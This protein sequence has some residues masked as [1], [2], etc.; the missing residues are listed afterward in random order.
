[1]LHDFEH[2]LHRV[3]KKEKI[4]KPACNRVVWNQL[5]MLM[6]VQLTKT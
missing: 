3:V 6:G 2:F 4:S 1:M 5:L